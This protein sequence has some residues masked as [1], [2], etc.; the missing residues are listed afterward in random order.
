MSA[1]KE[2]SERVELALGRIEDQWEAADD[3]LPR[4][5]KDAIEYAARHYIATLFYQAFHRDRTSA[6]E[7]Y[8]LSIKTPGTDNDHRLRARQNV[9]REAFCDK[10]VTCPKE[11]RLLRVGG[12]TKEQH[13]I[14]ATW[15]AGLAQGYLKAAEAHRIAA[16]EIAQRGATCLDDL[17]MSPVEVKE[18]VGA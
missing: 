13:E 8:A 4:L 1:K 15:L 12:M 10:I 9:V 16:T 6:R 14:Y 17:N 7:E 18:L 11:G 2:L 3:I 5:S